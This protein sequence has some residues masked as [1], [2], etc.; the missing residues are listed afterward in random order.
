M[1]IQSVKSLTQIDSC[2]HT[3]LGFREPHH[4]WC[5]FI[6]VRQG[7]KCCLP[8]AGQ[9]H[10]HRAMIQAKKEAV[11]ADGSACRENTYREGLR[12]SLIGPRP[13]RQ[14]IGHRWSQ[15]LV[16]W[17]LGITFFFLAST[18]RALRVPMYL[19]I[20]WIIHPRLLSFKGNILGPWQPV[21]SEEWLRMAMRVNCNN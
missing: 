2:I 9:L 13:K 11:F 12:R 15:R 18:A 7:F 17:H 8:A 3:V 21:Y 10:S 20:K 1:A 5:V 4:L 14:Q 6:M 19:K 16:Q